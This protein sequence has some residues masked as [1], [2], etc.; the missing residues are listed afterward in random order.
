LCSD[1]LTAAVPNG[2]IRTILKEQSDV[3]AACKQ[4]VSAAKAAGSSDNIT[5]LVVNM[6]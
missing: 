4:L 5:V 1:G 3:E 2:Q 6:H